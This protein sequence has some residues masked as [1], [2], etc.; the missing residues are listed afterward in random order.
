MATLSD[1]T[2]EQTVLEL[3]ENIVK[4]IGLPS[5][6]NIESK[7]HTEKMALLLGY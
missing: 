6:H 1:V 2:A 5:G 7:K 4:A 3:K